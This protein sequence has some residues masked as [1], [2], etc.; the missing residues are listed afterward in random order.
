MEEAAKNNL[1]Q[2]D[3]A[4]GAGGSS[5]V[6]LDGRLSTS[7][8]HRKSRVVVVGE[9]DLPDR[10]ISAVRSD[11]GNLGDGLTATLPVVDESRELL[12]R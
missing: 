8:R 11:S 4:N 10:A 5:F 6:Q 9:A 1:V 12:T 2:T 7:S 3:T